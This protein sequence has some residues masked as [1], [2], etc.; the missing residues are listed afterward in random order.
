MAD[1]TPSYIPADGTTLDPD[2]W[3]RNLDSTTAAESI[4]GELNGRLSDANFDGAA[5]IRPEHPKP[6]ETFRWKVDTLKPTCDYFQDVFN[7]SDDGDTPPGA[8]SLDP[9]IPIAGASTRVYLPYN[10]SVVMYQV[11]CFYTLFQMRK[12]NANTPAEP[13]IESDAVRTGPVTNLKVYIDG[14]GLDYTQRRTPRTYWPARIGQAPASSKSLTAR[15]NRLTQHL[16][17]A[18]LALAN[19]SD[20][21]QT[22]A[23]WHQIDLRIYVAPNTGYEQF[24]APFK[25]SPNNNIEYPIRHRCRVGIRAARVLALL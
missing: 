3:N 13:A 23:G 11:S 18:H 5:K 21:T 20:P 22:Q 7:Q 12:R 17:I 9:F 2:R 19:G 25:L 4:Y 15:E 16:D 14:V 8:G 6:L 10:C 24:L 1:I